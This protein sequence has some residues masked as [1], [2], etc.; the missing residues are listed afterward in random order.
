MGGRLLDWL[1]SGLVADLPD[2]V[3]DMPTRV[4]PGSTAFY[5]S[6]DTQH[7]FVYDESGPAWFDIDMAAV[8][9]VS[10]ESLQDMI[11]AFII[12]GAGITVT[13]DD[14]SNALVIDCTITQYTN[15]MAQDTVAA[16]IAAGTHAGVS[17]VYDDATNTLSFTIQEASSAEVW[18]GTA[19]DRVITPK[20]LKDW[21]TPVALVDGATITMDGATGVNFYVTLAGNRAFANPTNF[22]P[23]QFGVIH[24]TQDGTGSRTLTFGSNFKFAGV[25][26][27]SNVLSTTAAAVD[28]IHYYVRADGTITCF[29][30]KG[31]T[32]TPAQLK[33]DD[34]SNVNMTTPPTNGQVLAYDT[35]T[36]KWKP[37][38][39]S[40]A[41]TPWYWSPPLASAFT[42]SNGGGAGNMVL[43]DDTDAGLL[44]EPSTFPGA[45]STA[46]ALQTLASSTADWTMTARFEG[47]NDNE[48]EYNGFGLC[49][50]ESS[51]GKFVSFFFQRSYGN[52]GS[53]A[54]CNW[55]SASAFSSDQI[56]LKGTKQA[57]Q[58]VVHT[59]GNYLFQISAAGKRF[60]TI[61]TLS[62][63]AFLASRANKVGFM[64]GSNIAAARTFLSFACQNFSIV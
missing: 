39:A 20:K 62:D 21:R 43:T 52:L 41:A 29:I 59:G 22:N 11:A 61:L 14:V 12:Q 10:T 18:G 35:A 5:F 30:I 47:A 26:Y 37:A 57:W 40:G 27:G 23:G 38:T 16:L 17:I 60:R 42:L 34:L 7:L 49:L 64:M 50:Y 25:S 13:Y 45:L 36:S 31:L 63:T 33:L 54:V 19:Q 58:R 46:F 15:E 32:G 8:T 9:A 3:V 24:V 28:A 44:I 48:A 2:P 55:T 1:G 6:I 53:I 56:T 4:V 51:T